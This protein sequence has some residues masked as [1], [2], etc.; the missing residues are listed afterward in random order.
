MR[1]REYLKYMLKKVIE[2]TENNEIK[3]SDELVQTL[4]NHL[5]DHIPLSKKDTMAN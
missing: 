3:T 5:S 4:I 1:E 2:E